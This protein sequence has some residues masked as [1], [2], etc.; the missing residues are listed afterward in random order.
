MEFRDKIQLAFTLVFFLTAKPVIA[1]ENFTIQSTTSTY[2]SGLY[3]YLLPILK[4][5]TGLSARVISVGTGQAIKNIKNGHGDILIVH[6]KQQE[7]KFISQG[8]GLERIP[9]MQN[10]YILIGPKE[11]TLEKISSLERILTSIKEK[12]LTFISRGDNSGTHTREL[13]LWTHFGISSS[14]H[15]SWYKETGAGMGST[16]NIAEGL[17]AYTL[18]DSASWISHK[19]KDNLKVIYQGD[20]ILKNEYSIV[21]ANP[22]RIPHI[23]QDASTIFTNWLLSK[24]TLLKIEKFQPEGKSLFTPIYSSARD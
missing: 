2:N 22:R 14:N 19:N 20:E 9:F 10:D 21:T 5:E 16:L 24:E 17:K 3:D 1:E 12:K 7:E 11:S 6:S 13:Y 4:Q 18:T 8:Y 23:K 15:G